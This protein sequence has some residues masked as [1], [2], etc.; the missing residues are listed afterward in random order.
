MRSLPF[1]SGSFIEEKTRYQALTEVLRSGFSNKEIVCPSRHHHQFDNW[2]LDNETTMLLMPAW[3]PGEVGGIKVVN[4]NP[5]YYN[6]GRPSIQGAYLLMDAN[7][8]DFLAVLDG[9][10]LTAKRTAATSALASTYLSR[11]ESSK[12]LMI[13]TGILSREM[14][15]AHAAVRP[16]EEVMIWGRTTE[17]IQSVQESIKKEAFRKVDHLSLEEG[18]AWADIICCATSATQPLILGKYLKPGQHLDLVG[19]FKP[20]A[21]EA[22]DDVI[23]RSRIFLDEMATGLVE[24]G[25]I[26]IP[27]KTGILKKEEIVGDLFQLCRSEITGRKNDQE[28]SLFKSVGHAVED[29]VAAKHYLDLYHANL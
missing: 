27:L 15:L 18:L 25:D 8:G 5:G 20:H 24:S 6:S 7:K 26:V 12:L 11:P 13:G 29:L 3:N 22:D 14:I 19:S 2:H 28:I 16:I 17:K 1:I 10:A 4:I 9:A 23:R 21:R